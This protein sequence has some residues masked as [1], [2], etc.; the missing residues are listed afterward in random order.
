MTDE[1]KI[2][3]DN[4]NQIL[5]SSQKSS[6]LIAFGI[7]ASI[8]SFGLAFTPDIWPVAIVISIFAACAFICS[9]IESTRRP[10]GQ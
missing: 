1:T 9:A 8:A 10:L 2:E 5:H 3:N 6:G 4:E 7:V